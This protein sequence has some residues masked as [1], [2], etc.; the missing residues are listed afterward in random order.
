MK[1]FLIQFMSIDIPT[2]DDDGPQAGTNFGICEGSF[3]TE[4]QAR[5]HLDTVVIPET[6]KEEQSQFDDED[7]ID[8]DDKMSDH[9]DVVVEESFNGDKE[10]NVYYNNSHDFYNGL[11]RSIIYKV[12]E[13]EL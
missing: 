13:V 2:I 8:E 10:V 6:V 3:D 11:T 4:E 5:K 1:K 12:V 7:E 9:I